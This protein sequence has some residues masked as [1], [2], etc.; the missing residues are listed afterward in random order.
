MTIEHNNKRYI[1][2]EGIG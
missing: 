2:S 1:L